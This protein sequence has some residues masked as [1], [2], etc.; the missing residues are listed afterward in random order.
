MTNPTN[1]PKPK[2]TIKVFRPPDGQWTGDEPPGETR[3]PVLVEEIT[4]PRPF[5]RRPTTRPGPRPA[6]PPEPRRP[7]T[8]PPTKPA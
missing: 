7:T 8:R 5:F 2:V 6:E 1:Q 3:Q 4:Y